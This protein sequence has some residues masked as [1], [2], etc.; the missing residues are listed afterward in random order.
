MGYLN[1]NGANETEV[2]LRQLGGFIF[3]LI[4]ISDTQNDNTLEYQISDEMHVETFNERCKKLD[5]PIY[6]ELLELPSKL[7]DRDLIISKME[8]ELREA[9]DTIN[10]LKEQNFDLK[11][12]R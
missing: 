7:E 8:D 10:L 3:N 5:L 9:T 2:N 6:N 12:R 11:Y 1:L 4:R